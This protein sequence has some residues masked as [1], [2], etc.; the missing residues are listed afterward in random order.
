[1]S[2][3]AQFTEL[4]RQFAESQQQN[5]LL[6]Q[7]LQHAQQQQESLPSSSSTPPAHTNAH[8][9]AASHSTPK[10]IKPTAFE[11]KPHSNP[12]SWLFEMEQYMHLTEVSADR[13]VEF[14]SAHFRGIATQ[15]WRQV[16]NTRTSSNLPRMT[17]DE[18]RTAFLYRFRPYDSSRTARLRLRDIIQRSSVEEYNNAFLRQIELIDNMH[19]V[20]QVMQYTLGL[21]KSIQNDVDRE[22]PKT[23]PEAMHLAAQA[24]TR[25][26]HLSRHSSANHNQHSGYGHRNNSSYQS[27]QQAVPM[28][29]GSMDNNDDTLEDEEHKC[30][31]EPDQFN[32]FMR[33]SGPSCP[34]NSRPT[35]LTSSSGAP[36]T[37]LTPEER[38]KC[39]R[40]G[41]CFRCRQIGHTARECPKYPPSSTASGPRH[42]K[43]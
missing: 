22:R 27:H 30:Y 39:A 28:E 11:G 21:K 43:A 40:E 4:Q 26:Y 10:P 29:L 17:W 16:F 13:C 42:P 35:S 32:A 34:S 33:R 25:I 38:E 12:E 24:D 23:L 41:R 20:D 31:V 3:E 14:A 8:V 1:M 5:H 19:P 18:F 9:H 37:K 6:V 2:L 7:Q 15:W 36:L